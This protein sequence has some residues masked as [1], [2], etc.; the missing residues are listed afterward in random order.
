LTLVEIQKH[1]QKKNNTILQDGLPNG[2]RY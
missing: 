2:L 1:Q